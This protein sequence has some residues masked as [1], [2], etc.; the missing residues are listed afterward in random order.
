MKLGIITSIFDG[1]TFEEMIDEVSRIGYETIEVASWPQ[2][3]AERR[4]AGVTWMPSACLKTTHTRSTCLTTPPS[5]TC[6]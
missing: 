2:G 1:W 4:Y 5:I 3:K 6:K